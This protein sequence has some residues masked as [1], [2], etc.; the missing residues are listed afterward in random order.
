MREQCVRYHKKH[1][2]VWKLF[3]QFTF[4]LIER[5]FKH[6]AVST[7]FERIRWE[8]DQA[9]V[10]GRSTFKINNNY[11]PFYARRFMKKHPDHEGFFRTRKQSSKKEPATNLPELGPKDYE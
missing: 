8:T 9:D 1:P 2:K 5:G 10:E 4:E 7:V 3:E 11:K 6:N